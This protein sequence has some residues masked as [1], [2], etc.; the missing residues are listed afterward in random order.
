MIKKISKELC[1]GCGQ[2]VAVCTEDVL[3]IDD[4]TGKPYAKYPR[5]C[6]VCFFC[7]YFCPVGAIEL[8]MTRGR[9]MPEVW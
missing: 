4:R 5:D 9:K 6:V 1:I 8:E 7:E 2:C 3:R